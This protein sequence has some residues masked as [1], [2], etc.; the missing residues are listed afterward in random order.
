MYPKIILIGPM[1]SGKSTIGEMLAHQLGI[2]QYS[3]DIVFLTYAQ[4]AGFSLK[5]ENYI[6]HNQSWLEAHYYR[7]QFRPQVVEDLI[8]E[9]P[10]SVLDLG[11]RDTVYDNTSHFSRVSRALAPCPNVVLLL[12][13]P[14]SEESISILKSR[15]S[16]ERSAV[17]HQK[18]AMLV[19]EAK[20]DLVKEWVTHS[21]N[22]HLAKMIIYTQEKTPKE[23]CNEII[24]QLRS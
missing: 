5:T 23:V 2:L 16:A 15:I 9:H 14:D 21:S 19:Q 6:R 24:K 11:A 20:L 3:L 13:S 10:N 1:C 7:Q 18:L 22:F 17:Q 12:P 8:R 4:K